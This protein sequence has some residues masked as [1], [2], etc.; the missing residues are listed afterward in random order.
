MDGM[1]SDVQYIAPRENS[2]GPELQH[3][4]LHFIL[5]ITKQTSLYS[6]FITLL[7]HLTLNDF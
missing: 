1:S 5:G 4:Y 7:E 6:S 2:N 3:R